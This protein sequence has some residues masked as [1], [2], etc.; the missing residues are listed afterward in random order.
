MTLLPP[1]TELS[2][3]NQSLV[4]L[5]TAPAA[6]STTG[7]V[8]AAEITAGEN[9]SLHVVGSWFP[10]ADTDRAS[11]QRKMGSKKTVQILGTSTVALPDLTVTHLAQEVDATAGNEAR[12][13][14]PEGAIKYLLLRNGVAGDAA[15]ATGDRAKVYPV[16]VGRPMEAETAD[17][18]G[19]EEALTIP[20]GFAPGFDGPIDVTLTA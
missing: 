9:I 19:G 6:L 15:L 20:L 14:L 13:A 3:G 4:V 18:A 7:N 8:T 12:A 17:D 2:Y 10:T 16:T 11:T 5:D 1:E